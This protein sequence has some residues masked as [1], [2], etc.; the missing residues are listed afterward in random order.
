MSA[1]EVMNPKEVEEDSCLVL[2]GHGVVGFDVGCVDSDDVAL[3][4]Q[5]GLY[6]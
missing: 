2:S 5:V 6:R 4:D 3:I 1:M